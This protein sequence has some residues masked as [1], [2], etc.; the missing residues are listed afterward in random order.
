MIKYAPFDIT[1]M[2]TSRDNGNTVKKYTLYT[3]MHYNIG[4]YNMKKK[5]L[6]IYFIGMYR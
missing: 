2:R 1:I 6:P 3:V 5:Y 4:I